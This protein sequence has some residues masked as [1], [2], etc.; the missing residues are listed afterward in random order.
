MT[1]RQQFIILAIAIAAVL[2]A[3]ALAM[4]PGVAHGIL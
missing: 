3:V 1:T 2:L 4:N